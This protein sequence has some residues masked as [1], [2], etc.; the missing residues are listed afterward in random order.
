M[1]TPASDA[2]TRALVLATVYESRTDW[3]FG[4]VLELADRLPRQEGAE[5]RPVALAATEVVARKLDLPSGSEDPG[6]L[7]EASAQISS[8]ELAERLLDD[9]G[10]CGPQGVARTLEQAGTVACEGA[11]LLSILFLVN[12]GMRSEVPRARRWNRRLARRVEFQE[13]LAGRGPSRAE[14]VSAMWAHG[15]GIAALVVLVAGSLALLLAVLVL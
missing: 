15:C 11:A 12:I 6:A 2:K 13:A 3:S 9:W 1:T 7:E 4:H 5:W 8:Y 14:A 10:R